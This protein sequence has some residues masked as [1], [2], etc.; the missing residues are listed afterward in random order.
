MEYHHIQYNLELDKEKGVE[1][2]RMS[3]EFAKKGL[4]MLPENNG[5]IHAYYLAIAVAGENEVKI[6][7]KDIELALALINQII[8]KDPEYALYYCT[9][10]RLFA[11]LGNYE[12]ALL[13]IKRAR[14]LESPKHSDWMLRVSDYHRIEAMIRDR[15][16]VKNKFMYLE[17]Q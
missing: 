12:S 1:H 3:L 5:I 7:D 2:L 11:N 13:N 4:N 8:H 6:E 14:T 15:S 9:R 16:I 10:G 17:S